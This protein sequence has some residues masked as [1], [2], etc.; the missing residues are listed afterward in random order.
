MSYSMNDDPTVSLCHCVIVVVGVVNGSCCV[1]KGP[2]RKSPALAT[3]V[4]SPWW[5]TFRLG[6]PH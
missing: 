3:A 1:L 5:H 6:T 2:S 4:H